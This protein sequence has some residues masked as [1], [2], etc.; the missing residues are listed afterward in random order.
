MTSYHLDKLNAFF[1][2]VFISSYFYRVKNDKN[3]LSF[4]I[5][6]VCINKFYKRKRIINETQIVIF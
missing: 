1:G 3:C 2:D 5:V 4:I 6:S